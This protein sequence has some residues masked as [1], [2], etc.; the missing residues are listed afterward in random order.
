MTAPPVLRVVGVPAGT[1]GGGDRLER[2]LLRGLLLALIDEGRR[3]AATP[4]GERW[5]H[6]LREGSLAR[7]G[8]ARWDAAGLGLFLTGA[9]RGP[10]SPRAMADDILALLAADDAAPPGPAL[11][12]TVGTAGRA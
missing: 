1:G 7:D 3:F 11:R 5:R 9:D 6:V 10:G 8:R 4:A 12:V 2:A